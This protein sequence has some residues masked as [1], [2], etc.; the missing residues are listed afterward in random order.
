MSSIQLKYLIY[1]I[2][3]IN[4]QQCYIGQTI[5]HRRR[6]NK[7]G[8][9]K[10]EL[11][12]I[13][14]RWQMHLRQA[15]LY[16]LTDKFH[17]AI[18]KY[19]QDKFEVKLIDETVD[20]EKIDDLENKWIKEFNSIE[21]GFNSNNGGAGIKLW[22][23]K[24]SIYKKMKKN[25]IELKPIK[26]KGERKLTRIYIYNENNTIRITIG[27]KN[28]TYD[29]NVSIAEDFV[30]KISN[31][32]DKIINLLHEEYKYYKKTLRFENLSITGVRISKIPYRDK[33]IYLIACN[34]YTKEKPKIKICFGGV[35]IAYK[36]A[37]NDAIEFSKYI[38][39][40]DIKKLTIEN[41]V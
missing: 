17:E 24:I 28:S 40:D 19:G 18:R 29:E 21:N 26:E 30:N 37:Y 20:F 14:D 11:Y 13:Y 16:N 41:D 38:L 22:C 39:K 2:T 12:G 15:N 32:T 3:H 27:G 6:K 10:Y 4:T 33:N 36:D 23:D 1:K 25:K 35:K 9:M 8:S 34:V 31:N 7:D 5:S